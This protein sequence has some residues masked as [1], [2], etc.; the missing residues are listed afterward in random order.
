MGVA[1]AMLYIVGQIV[2]LVRFLSS[3]DKEDIKDAKLEDFLFLPLMVL[4]M[5]IPLIG[6]LP[7]IGFNDEDSKWETRIAMISV[8]ILII[9]LIITLCNLPATP[10]PS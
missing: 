3:F 9:G 2:P 7:C 6:A 5:L 1:L 10:N 4:V 8:Y